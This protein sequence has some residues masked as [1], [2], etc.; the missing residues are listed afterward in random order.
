MTD[1]ADTWRQAMKRAGQLHP[2][3][4]AAA[5]TES[6]ETGLRAARFDATGGGRTTRVPCPEN[7]REQC[8]DGPEP[9]SHLVTSD[10]TGNQ[11]TRGRGRD[12]TTDDLRR[13]NQAN[14]EFVRASTAVIVWV[15][16]ELPETW[17][18]VLT[19]NAR[20]MPGTIQAGLDVDD[21][22][23]L[24]PLIAKVDRAV[25]AVEQIARDY[26]PHAPSADD[27]HWTDGLGPND[28]CQ[29]HADLHERYRRPR[30]A[31]KNICADCCQIAELLGQKPP[32]WLLEAEVDLRESRPLAW[33][34]AL[35]RCMDELGVVRDRT[36]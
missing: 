17:Q 32:R 35:S 34:A 3:R 14:T 2:D 6:A 29:W 30:L 1:L 11:A 15:S 25:G 7:E 19:V 27:R 4:V 28:V 23:H 10:P 18:Q 33:R 9:H 13:L 16:G 24:P 22:Y 12:S 36:G 20:L 8:D 26:L 31:G 21:E 5:I